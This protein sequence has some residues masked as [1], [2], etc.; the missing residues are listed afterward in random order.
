MNQNRRERWILAA[1]VLMYSAMVLGLG[2]F[3]Y[4]ANDRHV[5][6]ALDDS[7]IHMAIAKNL[8][9]HRT[10]GITPNEFSSSSSSPLWTSLLAALYYLFGPTEWLPLLL[11][12]LCGAAAVFII[13]RFGLDAGMKGLRL[14]LLLA[15]S[16]LLTP[17]V[18]IAFTGMEHLLH[19]CAVVLLIY[20][21]WRLLGDDS[22]SGLHDLWLFGVSA[23]FAVASRYE[24][25]F[26]IAVACVAL[27]AK[28]RWA[29]VAVCGI[30]ALI[31]VCV[32]GGF[33]IAHGEQFLPNSLLLNGDVPDLNSLGG[34]VSFNG[35]RRLVGN[36]HLYILMICLVGLFWWKRVNRDRADA[37][38]LLLLVVAAATA[39]HLQ[40][41]GTNHFYRYEAYLVALAIIVL[42]IQG[43]ASISNPRLQSVRRQPWA[44]RVSLAVMLLLLLMPLAKRATGAHLK[45]IRA[46]RN[47]YQQQYQ[48]GRFLHRYYDGEPVGANDIGAIN[49]FA[50]LQCLDLMGLGSREVFEHRRDGTFSTAI[51]RELVRARGVSVVVAYESWFKG[52]I[53]L[54]EEW[55]VVGTWT[56]S[57]N[58]ICGDSTVSFLATE[59]SEVDSL[60]AHLRSFA[61]ELPEGVIWKEHMSAIGGRKRP[62]KNEQ[63]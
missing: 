29:A 1:A 14:G 2:I 24:S 46:T 17:M 60:L 23:A 35:L 25:L 59:P 5:V 7:Y 50:R 34:I 52:T 15:A 16:I 27:A 47:I 56:I 13:W 63:P 31:P 4:W 54:P 62:I 61:P 57:H 41:A 9:Q 51:I 6:Y 11:N 48:M 53:S 21:L 49:Y 58:V 3:S 39:L 28:R 26:L 30:C 37:A 12:Y 42:S 43:R 45:T 38:S 20:F 33:A 40:F 22:S 19:L 8:V 55:T 18:P 32:L 44:A 36:T 10:F